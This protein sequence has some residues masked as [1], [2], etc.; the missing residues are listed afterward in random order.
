M[1]KT[2]K[3]IITIFILL[4]IW[5]IYFFIQNIKTSDK[6]IDKNN[7][8]LEAII[9]ENKNKDKLQEKEKIE[10]I[11]QT[12]LSKWKLNLEDYSYIKVFNDLVDK[13]KIEN[14]N[15][16]LLKEKPKIKII[17]TTKIKKYNDEYYTFNLKIYFDN[18][19]NLSPIIL[20]N[21]YIL[22]DEWRKD[23]LKNKKIEFNYDSLKKNIKEWYISINFFSTNKDFLWKIKYDLNH[24]SINISTSYIWKKYSFLLYY[25]K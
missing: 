22:N 1:E 24:F 6:N 3:Y 7:K 5:M 9:K 17:E 25:T 19:Y 13:N 10:N 2:K 4:T 20:K 18:L 15:K 16:K 23:L 12:F 21:L 8:E 11:I 14:L